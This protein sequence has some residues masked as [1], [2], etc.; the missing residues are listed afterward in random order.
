[1]IHPADFVC[2]PVRYMDC[3]NAINI[4][5]PSHLFIATLG[6]P[7]NTEYGPKGVYLS[8]STDLIHWNKPVLVVTIAQLQAKEPKGNWSYM[9]FSLIDPN[10]KDPNFTTITDEPSLYYVRS[11]EEHPPY[12]RTLFRQKIR[13]S[14][15]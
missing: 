12:V 14:L 11:D 5:E 2:L 10:S 3:V 13:L 8:T 4:H 6:D 15:K 9:Y 1:V 7:F